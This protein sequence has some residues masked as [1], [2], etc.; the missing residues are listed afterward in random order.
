MENLLNRNYEINGFNDFFNESSQILQVR[1]LDEEYSDDTCN[2]SRCHLF[3]YLF[4]FIF[5][6]LKRPTI[7]QTFECFFDKRIYIFIFLS[8]SLI[9]KYHKSRLRYPHDYCYKLYD[10][11]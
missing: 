5:I 8:S 6:R 4:I 9:V 3:I 10:V 2:D 11:N 7:K 1:R